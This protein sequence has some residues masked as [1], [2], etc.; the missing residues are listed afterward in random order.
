MIPWDYVT[1]W[2]EQAPWALDV[3]VEQDLVLSRAIVEIYNDASLAKGLAIRGGTAL[4]K[5]H[6]RPLVR[7]SEDID[8]V[9]ITPEPIGATMDAIRARLDPW[10]GAP[11]RQLH[12]GRVILV[13]RFASDS[14]PPM[15]IRLKL[16]INSREHFTVLGHVQVPFRVASRWFTGDA[17]VTTFAMDELAGTKLRA[18]YQR[19]KGR[20][21]FDLWL[22][23]DRGLLHPE[24][25]VACF[26]HYMDQGRTPVSRAELEANL[27]A[28]AETR[29]F[30]DDVRLLLAAG[31]HYDSDVAFEVVQRELAAR[32]PG[33]PWK[34]A[35]VAGT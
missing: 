22:A 24:A 31:L 3:Q 7:Y 16:E 10:L 6:L 8:L 35:R 11:R 25:V 29:A 18:L 34:G 21:L 27:A 9:Q 15:P 20:D 17:M 32:I 30:Q 28:K 19:K 33:D 5:L 4:Y 12:E 23:L 2:R 14:V 26:L 1:E 13:Y